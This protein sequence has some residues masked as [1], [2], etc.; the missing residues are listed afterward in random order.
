MNSCLPGLTPY[1]MTRRISRRALNSV[2]QLDN[3]PALV[4]V[5]LRQ[6]V[7][8]FRLG[9]RLKPKFLLSRRPHNLHVVSS[10]NRAS[11]QPAIRQPTC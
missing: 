2:D 11:G 3:E 1:M 10:M 9:L 7:P 6:A 5:R 4:P 8:W